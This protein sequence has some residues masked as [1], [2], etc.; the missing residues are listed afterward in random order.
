MPRFFFFLKSCLSTSYLLMILSGI[1]LM[2]K[3]LKMRERWTSSF[4]LFRIC[5]SV[6]GSGLGGKPLLLAPPPAPLAAM[7]SPTEPPL[8]LLTL[9]EK[10]EAFFIIL[11]ALN[12]EAFYEK[13]I[14][15][16]F[17]QALPSTMP[18]LAMPLFDLPSSNPVTV[19]LT[20][21]LLPLLS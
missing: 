18:D 17:Y 14:F 4:S 2:F 20:F 7:L 15:W 13:F 5:L 3:A 10:R 8:P 9:I 1:F 21:L 12:A 16:I 19:T 6:N 11:E